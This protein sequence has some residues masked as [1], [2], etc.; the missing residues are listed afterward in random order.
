MISCTVYLELWRMNQYLKFQYPSNNMIFF[1]SMG[2]PSIEKRRF[3]IFLVKDLLKTTT[4]VFDRL[5]LRPQSEQYFSSLDN[6]EGLLEI[7]TIGRDR[8]QKKVS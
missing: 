5:T 6:F 4:F 8:P 7:L 1:I 2:W 3:F